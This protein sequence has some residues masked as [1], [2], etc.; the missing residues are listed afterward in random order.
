M[1][2]EPDDTLV[3]D[4][5]P[6]A[7][8]G[9]LI[10]IRPA[11]DSEHNEYLYR[12]YHKDDIGSTSFG[13]RERAERKALRMMKRICKAREKARREPSEVRYP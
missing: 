12:T 6:F 7:G 5:T 4:V 2:S 3:A 8:S 10:K 11:S 9:W 13:S 1:T